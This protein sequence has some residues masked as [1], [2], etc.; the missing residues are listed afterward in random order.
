MTGTAAPAGELA[1]DPIPEAPA[2]ARRHVAR[3]LRALGHGD[4]VDDAKT[5]VSELVTN[6]MAEM[7]RLDCTAKIT[8][9][10]AEHCGRPVLEVRDRSTAPPREHDAGPLATGGRGIHIVRALAADYGY[11]ILA[12]GKVVWAVLK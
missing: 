6:A 5:I 4:L 7:N 9:C 10:L 3:A 11:E 12:T 2:S 8:V 1:L